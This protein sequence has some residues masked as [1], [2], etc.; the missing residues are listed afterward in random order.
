MHISLMLKIY[1]QQ[2][3]WFCSIR[4]TMYHGE[5]NKHAWCKMLL[6]F[7]LFGILLWQKQLLQHQ[8]FIRYMWKSAGGIV[9][10]ITYSHHLHLLCCKRNILQSNL[11]KKMKK[12]KSSHDVTHNN[13]WKKHKK[14]LRNS[15]SEKLP[16]P[17]LNL[18]AFEIS[19][20]LQRPLLFV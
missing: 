2:H 3:M 10:V 12:K 14:K 13:V 8:G 18:Q 1:W 17:N 6:Q 11:T 9:G 15:Q 20:V 4:T 16:R 5:D 19:S 7:T